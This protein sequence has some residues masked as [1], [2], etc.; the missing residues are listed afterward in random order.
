MTTDT[1]DNAG[2]NNPPAQTND[3][4]ELRAI[5]FGTLRG[6]KDGTLNPEKAKAINDTAQTIINS[7]KVEVDYLK[8]IGGGESEFIAPS[9]AQ[10]ALG[11]HQPAQT[12][13]TPG[14]IKTVTQLPGATVTQHRLRG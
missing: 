2:A 14:G 8:T 10:P 5:L 9:T 7:A 6:V 13:Q 11:H 12:T 4:A 1:K 3:I